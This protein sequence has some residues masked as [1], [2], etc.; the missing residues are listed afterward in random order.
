MKKSLSESVELLERIK[1]RSILRMVRLFCGDVNQFLID[2]PRIE[3]RNLFAS[4]GYSLF[5]QFESVGWVAF[6]ENECEISV[7][8]WSLGALPALEYA[9]SE[10]DNIGRQQYIECSDEKYS[11]PYWRGFL[12]GKVVELK[13]ISLS[14]DRENIRPFKNERGL[15]IVNDSG[16][17]LIIETSLA[18]KGIPGGINLIRKNQIRAQ[19]Q[20]DLVLRE[21]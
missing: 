11:E 12:G 8:I 10:M 4:S 20:E 6:A 17:D 1:G 9:D 19:L 21:I 13:I 15:L 16:G 3:E 18:E 7:G 2:F 14:V 5:I